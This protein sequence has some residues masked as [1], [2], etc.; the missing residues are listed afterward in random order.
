MSGQSNEKELIG[1]IVRDTTVDFDLMYLV[2]E[3]GFMSVGTGVYFKYDSAFSG[4]EFFDRP[5]FQ[6]VVLPPEVTSDG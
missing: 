5:E 4:P 3:R 1:K 6:V 2:G